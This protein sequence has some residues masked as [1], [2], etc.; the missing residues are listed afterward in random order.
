M[1]T[2]V[3]VVPDVNE[4]LPHALPL[5][6][7]YGEAHTAAGS[8]ANARATIEWP[9]LFIT[10]Y[11]RPNRCVLF[12]PV[13]DANPMFHY[14]ES[15]WILAG[16]NDVQFLAHVLPKMAEYSDN[17]SLFHG[18]YGFRLRRWFGSMDEIDQIERAIELLKRDPTSR[19]CV[20]S[21]WDP[22]ADLGA[23]TKDMPCND[24]LM[25]KI[26]R[27]KLNLTVA[28]RSNDVV[29]GCYGANVVQFSMLL[30]YM[31][32]RLGVGVGTYCQQSDSFHVYSDNPYWQWFNER[33]EAD[34]D[35]WDEPL[36]E[37]RKLYSSFEDKNLFEHHIDQFD[38]ELR[39]FFLEADLS[40]GRRGTIPLFAQSDA[41]RTAIKMWNILHYH[42]AKQHDD[43]RTEAWGI[44]LPDWREAAQ[45]W[46]ARR[47]KK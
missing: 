27:G 36:R 14:L 18:A 41:V 1:A 44:D 29:W 34:I 39:T 31:A 15:M 20:L 42:R 5:L 26:R 43:A 33:Y 45:R 19:Q 17:G 32:A 47:S 11:T 40:M 28:N 7:Q 9:G 22:D 16:R 25:F 46:L 23:K 4:A 35:Y 37:T 8:A 13:R 3:L 10:E 2:H 12:D 30:M 38:N 6:R 21:I 24:L